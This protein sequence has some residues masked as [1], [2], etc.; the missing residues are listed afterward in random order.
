MRDDLPGKIKDLLSEELGLYHALR[1][2]VSRELEAIVLD[3]DMEALLN[4][5][6]E[7]QA[8]ISQLQLLTDSWQDVLSELGLGGTRGSDGFWAQLQAL[9]PESH[10]GEFS[11]LLQETRVAA[12]DLMKGEARAQEELEKH[13]GG[14]R[15]KLAS[16]TRGREAFIGYTKMGGNTFAP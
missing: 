3:E 6:Q 15:E 16:M 1:M 10:A 4:I 13:L 14:L 2:M 8:L 11:R 7:K 9:L 12:E 5:L